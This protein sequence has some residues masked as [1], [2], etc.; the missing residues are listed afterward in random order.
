MI[1]SNIKNYERYCFNDNFKK[2]FEFLLTANLD[3]LPLG[4]TEISDDV[5]IIKENYKTINLGESFWEAHEK[6]IDIQ[7]MLKGCEKQA[8]APISALTEVMYSEEKDLKLLKGKV[9]TFCQLNEGN[10][11]VYFPEDGHMPA[12]NSETTSAEVVKFIVKIRV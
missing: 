1:A 4:R 2:A 9:Q 8:Y 11:I 5:F 7:Y 10:F 6:F 12:L 3:A